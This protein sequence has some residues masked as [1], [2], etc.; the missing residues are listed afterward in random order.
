MSD[1]VNANP[2]ATLAEFLVAPEQNC[3]IDGMHWS[4]SDSGIQFPA[5]AE[6]LIYALAFDGTDED[7]LYNAEELAEKLAEAANGLRSM[8]A[9][10]FEQRGAIKAAAEAVDAFVAAPTESNRLALVDVTESLAWHPI[11]MPNELKRKLRP[12]VTK[13]AFH[14]RLN[15]GV[16]HN[17]AK[18]YLKVETAVQKEAA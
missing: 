2:A 4:L 10:Y 12:F 9:A 1:D 3:T 8:I 13:R 17:V 6:D 16:L 18:E 11:P 7:L 15:F 14:S 5:D